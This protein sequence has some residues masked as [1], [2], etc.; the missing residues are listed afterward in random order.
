MYKINKK[1]LKNIKEEFQLFFLY[2]CT[3]YMFLFKSIFLSF[4]VFIIFF[5]VELYCLSNIFLLHFSFYHYIKKDLCNIIKF[6][7]Y[8]YFYNQILI[9][10]ITLF[11][12]KKNLWKNKLLFIKT[13][14][15]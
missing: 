9:I 2:I 13:T 14:I 1:N 8:N 11:D 6:L 4:I 5:H 7:L 12:H 3:T 10:K 15:F